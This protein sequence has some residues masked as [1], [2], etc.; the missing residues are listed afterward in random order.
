MM[1]N[2][3]YDGHLPEKEQL[4]DC[5]HSQKQIASHYCTYA[6]ECADTALRDEFL[7]ILNDEQKINTE[8]F[9]EMS[10]RGWYTPKPADSQTLTQLR[11]KFI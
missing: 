11:Q 1:N 9:V 10:S 8:L 4:T 2:V 6:A 7:C 5:L 3:T